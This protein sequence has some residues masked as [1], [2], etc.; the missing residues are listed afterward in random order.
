[1]LIIPSKKT[2]KEKINRMIEKQKCYAY[3]G[4]ECLKCKSTIDLEFHHR[5]PDDKFIDIGRIWNLIDFRFLKIE[6][7]KCDLLC[8]KCHK[9][10]HNGGVKLIINVHVFDNKIFFNREKTINKKRIFSKLL[11]VSDAQRKDLNSVI[12]WLLTT[13]KSNEVHIFLS[14]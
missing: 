13:Y 1:M 12:E 10:I 14:D 3:L 6:L 4:G 8:T 7:D 2:T 5:N 9:K 11:K